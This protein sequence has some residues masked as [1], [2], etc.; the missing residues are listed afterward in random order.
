MGFQ[1]LLTGI[2]S[3]YYDKTR[4]YISRPGFTAFPSHRACDKKLGDIEVRAIR[5]LFGGEYFKRAKYITPLWNLLN[6]F[7]MQYKIKVQRNIETVCLLSKK[8]W[9]S[10]VCGII[11]KDNGRVFS[12]LLNETFEYWNSGVVWNLLN[13]R[14]LLKGITF[15]KMCDTF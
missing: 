11:K 6:T 10:A 9:F 3:V 15:A 2:L 7:A 8:P 4:N 1:F 12:G 5:W 13:N 14:L